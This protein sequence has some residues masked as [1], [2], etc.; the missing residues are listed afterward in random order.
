MAQQTSAPQ[1]NL[2]LRP[3]SKA[4]A[5][6]D[7]K[8]RA[9]I[10]KLE[11]EH[12]TAIEQLVTNPP[13]QNKYLAIKTA[14]IN[15]YSLSREESFRTLVSGLSL[16][17]RRP[18]ELYAEMCK[19]PGN[20]VGPEFIRTMWMDRMPKDMQMILSLAETLDSSILLELAEKTMSLCAK[21]ANPQVAAIARNPHKDCDEKFQI[22]TKEMK[23]LSTKIDSLVG[24]QR[25]SR[26]NS[27]H[28]QG[29]DS[30]TNSADRAPKLCFYHKKFGALAFKCVPKCSW[31]ENQG[32]SQSHQ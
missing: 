9:V 1:L 24:A 25:K 16:K 28:P 27:P 32:N 8:F 31:D 15:Y 13:G 20:A 29:S 4:V 23:N 7:E 14:L 17:G 6:D 26:S 21:N 3:A 10:T 18:S 12:P 19:L 11:Q 22:L 5:D 2:P 30:R